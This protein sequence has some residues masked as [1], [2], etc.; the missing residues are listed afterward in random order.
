M[1]TRFLRNCS[2]EFFKNSTCIFSNNNHRNYLIASGIPPK[3]LYKEIL[4]YWTI[5]LQLSRFSYKMINFGRFDLSYS[6]TDVNEI[7]RGH[8]TTNFNAYVWEISLFMSSKVITVWQKWNFRPENR[9]QFENPEA[10]HKNYLQQI[11]SSRQNL[12]FCWTHQEAMP[13]FFNYVNY[14]TFVNIFTLAKPLLVLNSWLEKSVK[15]IW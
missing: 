13:S 8:Q 10:L 9:I 5:Y 15:N 7:F 1:F 6:W 14:Q 11:C 2:K 4:H 12:Q 3:N